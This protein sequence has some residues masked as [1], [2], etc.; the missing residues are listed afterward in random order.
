MPSSLPD[1]FLDLPFQQEAWPTDVQNAH[2][3]LCEAYRHAYR[4]T[5]LEDPDPLQLAFHI[6]QISTDAIR[7]LQGLES[8][9]SEQGQLPDDWL[10]NGAVQLGEMVK[11]LQRLQT[12]SSRLVFFFVLRMHENDYFQ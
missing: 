5:D 4:L 12:F 8:H 6:N 10:H 9:H 1:N 2:V 3:I 7:I 11:E